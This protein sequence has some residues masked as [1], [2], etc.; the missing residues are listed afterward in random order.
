MTSC[1]TGRR[2]V[3]VFNATDRC[4][5]GSASTSPGGNASSTEDPH[6]SSRN[7][8][9]VLDPFPLLQARVEAIER[10]ASIELTVFEKMVSA[11]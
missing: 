9:N 7:Y 10:R 6:E 5:S 4:W 8:G 3:P 1:R 11:T 2:H